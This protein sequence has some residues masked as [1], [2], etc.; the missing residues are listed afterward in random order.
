MVR[1]FRLMGLLLGFVLALAIFGSP[2]RA[3]SPFGVMLFPNPG[4]DFNLALARARGLGVAWFRP[5]TIALQSGSFGS[6]TLFN[7]SGLK[8]AITVRN[9]SDPS[10]R[11]ASHPPA[12][13]AAFRKSIA[14]VVGAWRPDLLVV[15]TEGEFI[16]VL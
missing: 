9:S 3:D 10:P 15:E 7:R 5:P 11:T 8:L 1:P 14:A 16:R 6:P 4:E 13:L 12:D 2:A